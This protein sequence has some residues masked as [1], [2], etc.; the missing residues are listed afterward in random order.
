MSPRRWYTKVFKDHWGFPQFRL[1]NL[2]TLVGRCCYPVWWG[3]FPYIE[4]VMVRELKQF[5]RFLY[6]PN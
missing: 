4:F 2:F 5:L 3:V 6:L 1:T